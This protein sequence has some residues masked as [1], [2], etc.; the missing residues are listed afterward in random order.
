MIAVYQ[1]LKNRFFAPMELKSPVKKYIIKHRQKVWE[2]NIETG[3]I[4]KAEVLAIP[5]FDR[6]GKPCIK[7]ELVMKP[8][9]LYEFALNGENAV[10]KFE[11]RILESVGKK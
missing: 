10:R 11:Q 8:N 2:C 1:W 4:H 5:S 3:S 7:R 6:K 9:C